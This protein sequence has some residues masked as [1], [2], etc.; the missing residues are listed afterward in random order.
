MLVVYQ[1]EGIKNNLSLF[2][3]IEVGAKDKTMSPIWTEQG[4]WSCRP[5]DLAHSD[6][7]ERNRALACGKAPGQTD[8]TH[9]QIG[10]F[11]T[12]VFQWNAW[13]EIQ[14]AAPVM[15]ERRWIQTT[16]THVFVLL[17][18]MSLGTRSPPGWWRGGGSPIV[19]FDSALGPREQG[20]L[21][22]SLS[23]SLSLFTA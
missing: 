3:I 4:L 16:L 5:M 8:Q 1:R 15:V 10:H 17:S 18:P 2:K 12:T 7:W 21:S 22:L 13:W 11:R 23:L 20:P 9:A 14:I 6:P 19:L